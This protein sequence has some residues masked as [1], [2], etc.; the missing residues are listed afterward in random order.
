[1]LAPSEQ[2]MTE[3]EYLAFEEASEERHEYRQGRVVKLWGDVPTAMADGSATHAIIGLNAG[4]DAVRYA[5]QA[6]SPSLLIT[7]CILKQPTHTRIPMYR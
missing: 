1:M 6:A 5:A 4:A 2:Y 7:S 3:E